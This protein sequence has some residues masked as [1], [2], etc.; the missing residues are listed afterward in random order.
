MNSFLIVDTDRLTL[1]IE[2]I[3]L[4]E[5]GRGYGIRSVWYDRFFI[6]TFI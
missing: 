3:D 6:R 4:L 2:F 1:F 5:K